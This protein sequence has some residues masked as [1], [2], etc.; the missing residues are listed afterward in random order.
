MGTR[1]QTV[2]GVSRRAC[3]I[4]HDLKID[5]ES[6]VPWAPHASRCEYQP[7]HGCQPRT[8]LF[9][10]FRSY[11]LLTSLMIFKD[12]RCTL[13]DCHGIRRSNSSDHVRLEPHSCRARQLANIIIIHRPSVRSCV[14][15]LNSIFAFS[16][17]L[18][19]RRAL[20]H[21]HVMSKP[22]SHLNQRVPFPSFC[23]LGMIARVHMCMMMM[24][25]NADNSLN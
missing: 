18:V 25:M 8:D 23:R 2:Q 3:S 24:F 13:I 21:P 19:F 10:H 1:L 4:M 6:S 22:T 7:R 20:L 11:F 16:V 12:T 14:T 15:R 5:Q 9:Q 17:L